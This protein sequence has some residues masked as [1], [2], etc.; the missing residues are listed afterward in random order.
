[1]PD[2]WLPKEADWFIEANWPN[3]ITGVRNPLTAWMHASLLT[4]EFE[5]YALAPRSGIKTMTHWL[6]GG[7]FLKS[8]ELPGEGTRTSS[9]RR[10][11]IGFALEADIRDKTKGL[12]YSST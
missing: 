4:G 6:I 5:R 8:V 9:G 3:C 7:D 10:M 12:Q 1:M 11:L 2:V